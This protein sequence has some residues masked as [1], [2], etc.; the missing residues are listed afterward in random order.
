MKQLFNPV[1]PFL[2]GK[3]LA[4]TSLLLLLVI[5]LFCYVIFLYGGFEPVAKRKPFELKSLTITLIEMAC[6][7]MA[8][9]LLRQEEKSWWQAVKWF[10]IIIVMVELAGLIIGFG[11]YRNNYYL[12]YFFMPVSVA[13]T[14]WILYACCSEFA[15]HRR[16]ILYGMLLF[17]LPYIAEFYFTLTKSGYR[18]MSQFYI[19]IFFT[20]TCCLYYY[21]M[22]RQ[23]NH[24]RLAQH[25][26]FWIVT[27]IFVFYF[28]KTG[29]VFF[30]DYFSFPKVTSEI[31][32]YQLRYTRFFV[33]AA[34]NLILYGSWSYAFICRYREKT[35]AA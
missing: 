30:F 21:H 33:M 14:S 35:S 8:L 7:A 11:Y 10:M 24:I 16:W 9:C 6:L 22:L 19:C 25:P 20:I 28:C 4:L 12:Y 26:G 32:Q 17:F 13:F 18:L 34:L 29:V 2:Y 31:E 3:R 1:Q 5:A 23:Q 15:E 27:G